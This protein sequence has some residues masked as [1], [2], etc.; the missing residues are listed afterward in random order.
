[1]ANSPR[2]ISYLA[3]AYAAFRGLLKQRNLLAIKHGERQ[4]EG[5]SIH[6]DKLQSSRKA[7]SSRIRHDPDT[8]AKRQPP[9][10]TF[11][12]TFATNPAQH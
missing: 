4:F 6:A 8:S 2:Q 5:G 1:M 7:A 3:D 9:M 10:I 12:R 11:L